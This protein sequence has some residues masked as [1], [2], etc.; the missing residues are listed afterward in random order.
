M[1]GEG[2]HTVGPAS[3]HNK[4][5]AFTHGFPVRAVPAEHTAAPG[6]GGGAGFPMVRLYQEMKLQKKAA[7]GHGHES[8]H[9]HTR[10]RDTL[11]PWNYE[12]VNR[13][14]DSPADVFLQEEEQHQQLVVCLHSQSEEQEDGK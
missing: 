2:T 9:P 7:S 5:R 12:V 11:V 13:S 1:T 8:K 14:T 4:N 10:V 6:Q 3:P